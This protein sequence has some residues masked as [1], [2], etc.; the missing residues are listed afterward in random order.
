M[1]VEVSAIIDRP[2]A[3]VF[4]VLYA[5]TCETTLA[6]I[7][8]RKLE[9]VSEGPIGVGT[10]IRRRHTHSGSPLEGTMEDGYEPNGAFGGVIREGATEIAAE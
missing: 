8:T 4:R 1:R 5:I 6:G 3:D 9:Q 2:V 7:A 10:A